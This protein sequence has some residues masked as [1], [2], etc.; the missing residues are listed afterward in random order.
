[1][2]VNDVSGKVPVADHIKVTET[3]NKQTDIDIGHT[4]ADSSKEYEL[5]DSVQDKDMTDSVPSSDYNS[6]FFDVVSSLDEVLEDEKAKDVEESDG[7]HENP[8]EEND[9]TS[10]NEEMKSELVTEAFNTSGRSE[11]PTLETNGMTHEFVV[12]S[13]DR[14]TIESA[15]SDH[16]ADSHMLNKEIICVTDQ[17]NESNLNQEEQSNMTTASVSEDKLRSD[18]QSIEIYP[19]DAVFTD[20]SD[21]VEEIVLKRNAEISEISQT[22][23]PHNIIEQ[24]VHQ[25]PKT[26]SE[27][28]TQTE[29]AMKL[30]EQ[31]ATQPPFSQTDTVP[32][33][34]YT[35]SSSS[36]P[37]LINPSMS[38][39]QKEPLQSHPDQLNLQ[40]QST[41][42]MQDIL[43]L[44][45]QMQTPMD[46]KQQQANNQKLLQ[47]LLQQQQMLLAAS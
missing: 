22:H 26:N 28:P 35:I 16:N 6:A 46:S 38:Q 3:S 20:V 11:R 24:E 12:S 47:L 29:Q 10:E 17:A 36:G 19:N 14:S 30:P 4:A 41:N 23:S 13:T 34:V 1:M 31:T 5:S 43:K 2:G 39:M 32:A 18:K 44:Q 9:E 27:A 40:V 21:K 45:H 37:V 7:Q 25:E 15:E 33:N 8:V 42:L